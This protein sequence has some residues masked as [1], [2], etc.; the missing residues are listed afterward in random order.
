VYYER[1]GQVPGNATGTASQIEETWPGLG[2][3]LVTAAMWSDA[4]DM[5]IKV[6]GDMI[7]IR[8]FGD[9]VATGP[10][11]RYGAHNRQNQQ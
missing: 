8:S 5:T 6:D 9:E 1:K 3:F 10:K 11:T 4:I 2:N 7:K